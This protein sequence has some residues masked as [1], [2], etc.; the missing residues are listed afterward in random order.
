ME[1]N[2]LKLK[3]S[4][5]LKIGIQDEDGIS[6]GEYLEFDLEDIEYPFKVIKCQK[7][8]EKNMKE[9]KL[10]FHIIDKKQDV[11]KKG[12]ISSN[13]TEKLKLMA[14]FYKKE[15]EAFDLFLGKN[16]TKKILNGRNPYYSM[17]EDISSYIEQIMPI[18]EKN[19]IKITDLV[20]SKYDK[21]ANDVL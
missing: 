19:A 3:K 1:E 15:E 9:L 11:V 18:L 21:K 16:G 14:D 5:I 17:F 20:K 2:I 4:N 12:E 7:K 10:K 13:E 8:H 6:T